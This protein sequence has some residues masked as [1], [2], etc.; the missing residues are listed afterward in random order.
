[1]ARPPAPSELDGGWWPQSRDLAVELADLAS[2]FPPGQGEIS[3][4]SVSPT[5]W[6]SSPR[7]VAVGA[8]QVRVSAGRGNDLHV[9]ELK[10]TSR[11]VL[12]LLVVPS[13]MSSEQAE[14]AM[15]AAA[16]PGHAY[17]AESILEIVEESDHADS[18]DQWNDTG[19]A[20]W[21]PHPVPPSF[22]TAD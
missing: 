18:F 1:M 16:T 10:T 7:R 19:D 4:A 13:V 20:W 14:E 15:L 8:G 3:R 17:T 6:N 12:R 5:D 2:H 11:R 22:R 9:I 21:D